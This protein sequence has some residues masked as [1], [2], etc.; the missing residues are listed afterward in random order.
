MRL[1]PGA[2]NIVVMFSVRGG[3]NVD[4]VHRGDSRAP[5]IRDENGHRVQEKFYFPTGDGIRHHFKIKGTSLHAY[6][7]EEYD[8]SFSDNWLL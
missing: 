6:V 2:T 7:S 8:I 1:E 5:W 4:Y 3:A